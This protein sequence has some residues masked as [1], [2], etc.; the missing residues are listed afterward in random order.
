[1]GYPE[2]ANSIANCMQDGNGKLID[3]L[4]PSFSTSFD[5]INVIARG[6]LP[7]NDKIPSFTQANIDAPFITVATILTQVKNAEAWDIDDTTA[8]NH[9]NKTFSK[10]YTLCVTCNSVAINGDAWMPS[11]SIYTC[12]AGKSKMAP[13]AD[14]SVQTTCP[15]GCY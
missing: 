12:P 9:V 2:Y 5:M 10:N 1:M 13:C 6:T 8:K 3:T 11:F 7:F 15:L 4:N 14:L